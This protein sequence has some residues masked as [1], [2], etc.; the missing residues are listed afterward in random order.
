MFAVHLVVYDEDYWMSTC[1]A[2]V[3]VRSPNSVK[4]STWGQLKALYR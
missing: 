1:Q 4:P 2:W 3:E